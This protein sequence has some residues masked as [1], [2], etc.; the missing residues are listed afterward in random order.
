LIGEEM[1]S[2]AHLHSHNNKRAF[3]WQ[4]LSNRYTLDFSIEFSCP[5][6]GQGTT[7]TK[8]IGILLAYAGFV[9]FGMAPWL[10]LL[11]NN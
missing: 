1:V 3:F 5:N 4:L 10:G 6:C 9:A 7:F 11:A 2:S 8:W